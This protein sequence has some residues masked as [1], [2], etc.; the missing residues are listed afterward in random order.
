MDELRAAVS[1][2]AAS[3]EARPVVVGLDSAIAECESKSKLTDAERESLR[4]FMTKFR[5]DPLA[6]KAADAAQIFDVVGKMHQS[7]AWAVA[8]GAKTS[9]G[10]E[11]S[12]SLVGLT[13]TD[14]GNHILFEI[15]QMRASRKAPYVRFMDSF[16]KTADA[17]K[18]TNALAR[19][20]AYEMEPAEP[21]ANSGGSRAKRAR[22]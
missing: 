19:W 12:W 15:S 18:R 16:I 2:P 7:W 22:T 1:G 13:A 20:T 10:L 5:D 9:T 21:I 6:V 17:T 3:A 4:S 8:S 11:L 14:R